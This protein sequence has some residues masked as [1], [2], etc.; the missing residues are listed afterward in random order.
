[1]ERRLAGLHPAGPT[2]PRDAVLPLVCVP[3]ETS[4]Y[5]QFIGRCKGV[6]GMDTEGNPEYA[7]SIV[8]KITLSITFETCDNC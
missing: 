1:M 5:N 6:W 3:A 7:T 8:D 2:A 4:I